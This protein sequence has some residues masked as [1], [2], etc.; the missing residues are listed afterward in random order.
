MTFECD[1]EWGI[2]EVHV[3]ERK[4]TNQQNN[5]RFFCW[6][7]TFAKI[8]I[9]QPLNIHKLADQLQNRQRKPTFH[10]SRFSRPKKRTPGSQGYTR[11]CWREQG[12]LE[13]KALGYEGPTGD[14]GPPENRV[15]LVPRGYAR[16]RRWTGPVGEQGPL[17]ENKDLEENKGPAGRTR[18]CR[19][20]GPR[21]EQ[22]PAGEQGP[23]GEQG[24]RGDVQKLC[25]L[26]L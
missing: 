3:Q 7:I 21:G 24:H 5:P 15:L 2:A 9:N 1:L 26:E 6:S 17:Q 18:T 12:L 14:Q 10:S 25:W 4:R 22:G 8:N 20:T 13:N 11:S 23:R 16:T 19:R